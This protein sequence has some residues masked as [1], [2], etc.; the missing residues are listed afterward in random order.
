MNMNN[1]SIKIWILLCISLLSIANISGCSVAHTYTVPIE[2]TRHWTQE[3]VNR[4]GEYQIQCQRDTLGILLQILEKTTIRNI[5]IHDEIVY[6]E[7]LTRTNS[8]TFSYIVFDILQL[9][10]FLGLSSV[11]TIA[12]IIIIPIQGWEAGVQGIHM[13]PVIDFIS[14]IFDYGFDKASVTTSRKNIEDHIKLVKS[15][16][17]NAKDSE[18]EEIFK[19]RKKANERMHRYASH[20]THKQNFWSWFGW[21]V[22]GYPLFSTNII[23]DTSESKK[24]TIQ[25]NLGTREE[26]WLSYTGNTWP[27]AETITVNSMTANPQRHGEERWR[28]DLTSILQ[29]LAEDEPVEIKH[30]GRTLVTCQ[31]SDLGVRGLIPRELPS[32]QPI[33]QYQ[34]RIIDYDGDGSL[35]PEKENWVLIEVKN[36][37]IT[38]A[39]GLKISLKEGSKP[40]RLS[41][42][43]ANHSGRGHE[44]NGLPAE[45]AR[46]KSGEI[47]RVVVTWVPASQSTLLEFSLAEL[48]GKNNNIIA[49]NENHN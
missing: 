17:E 28:V 20:T 5:E 22:P 32:Q 31:A 21:L 33:L 40:I 48:T 23:S 24:T 29:K 44:M 19:E 45:T 38:P 49:I 8:D 41:Q 30:K 37:G 6:T 26:K 9:R 25:N 42:V 15:Y 39:Y 2:A 14:R 7:T 4:H 12:G 1:R 34:A 18:I 46:L 36:M 16:N 13:N 11:P 43:I 47:W 3:V 10:W 35:D 27:S